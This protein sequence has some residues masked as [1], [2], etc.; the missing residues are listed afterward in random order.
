[1]AVARVTPTLSC[2]AVV[3]LYLSKVVYYFLY[4]CIYVCMY[5]REYLRG[6]ST[7]PQKKKS[8]FFL[9]NEGKEVERKNEKK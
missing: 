2:T 9:K 5:A 8:I 1:M 3:K 7:P 4:V 6:D